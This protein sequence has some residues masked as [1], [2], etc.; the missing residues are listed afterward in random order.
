MILRFA[1]VLSSLLL[2]G[3]PVSPESDHDVAADG[4]HPLETTPGEAPQ[5]LATICPPQPPFG[6]EKGDQV[7]P[8]EFLDA[9]G[10]TGTLHDHCGQPLTLVYHFYGW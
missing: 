8:L 1:L 5:E 6:L 10:D 7:E 2:L 4:Y 3:C 9:W